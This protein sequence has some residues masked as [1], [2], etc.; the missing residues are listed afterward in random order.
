MTPGNNVVYLIF[1]T[2]VLLLL[3]IVFNST[4]GTTYIKNRIIMK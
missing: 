1:F 3:Y 4:Q 2:I